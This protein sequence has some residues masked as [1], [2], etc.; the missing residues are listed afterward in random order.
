M[1]SM[2]LNTVYAAKEAKKLLRAYGVDSETDGSSIRFENESQ[3]QVSKAFAALESIR[4]DRL[5]SNRAFFVYLALRWRRNHSGFTLRKTFDYSASIVYQSLGSY[6][7]TVFENLA[8]G[9]LLPVFYANSIDVDLLKRI[10]AEKIE[11][12]AI[13]VPIK[14]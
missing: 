1:I 9:F 14:L 10:A 12:A 2:E 4:G 5:N 8:G 11:A 7:L 3:E 13:N 6:T